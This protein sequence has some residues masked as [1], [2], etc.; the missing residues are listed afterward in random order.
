MIIVS[1]FIYSQLLALLANSGHAAPII[2]ADGAETPITIN[3]IG[4]PLTS[5]D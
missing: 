4:T 3:D 5:G 2:Q 1:D